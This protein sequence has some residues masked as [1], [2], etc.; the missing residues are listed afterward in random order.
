MYWDTV[1]LSFMFA[2]A[3]DSP[4]ASGAVTDSAG[5]PVPNQ[6]MT[7]TLGSITLRTST[8]SRGQYNFYGAPPGQGTVAVES[9]QFLVAVG[10]GGPSPT[11]RLNTPA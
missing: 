7:L 11:L 1:Y 2:F 8:N 6:A 3:T 4:S 5:K 10:A 9:Q